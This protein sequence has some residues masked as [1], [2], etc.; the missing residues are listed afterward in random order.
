MNPER[1][2]EDH[3]DALYAFYEQNGMPYGVAKARFGDPYNWILN[4]VESDGI[5][6]ELRHLED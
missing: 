3:F 5:P 1:F 6:Y 4:K 2:V